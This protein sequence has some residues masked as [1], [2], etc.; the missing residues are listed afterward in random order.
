MSLPFLARAAAFQSAGSETMAV[1]VARWGLA[2]QAGHPDFKLEVGAKGSG[3]APLALAK[4]AQLG[5]MS[6]RMKPE[7]LATLKAAVGSAPLELSSA[8]DA[9]EIVVN[10]KLPLDKL[11]LGQLKAIFSAGASGSWKTFGGP[12]GPIHLYGRDKESGTRQFFEEHVMGKGVKASYFKEAVTPADLVKSV[13]ADPMGIG[14]LGLGASL[15][16]V[17]ALPLAAKKGGKAYAFSPEDVYENHYPLA[18]HL[19]LY[20]LAK[21]PAEITDFLRYVLSDPGQMIALQVGF[22]PLSKLEREEVLSKL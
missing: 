3:T 13:A 4:D 11:D 8:M 16:G 21:R 7:E 5:A 6:R 22:L 20:V 2:Y 17:K 18:R 12:A 1:L 10:P 19:Y 15:E 14:Y 9:L